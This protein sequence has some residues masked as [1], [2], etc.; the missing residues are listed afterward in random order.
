[1][2]LDD[3]LLEKSK[4]WKYF[5]LEIDENLIEEH[6][7]SPNFKEKKEAIIKIIETLHKKL[8]GNCQ[9]SLKLF[10]DLKKLESDFLYNFIYYRDHLSHSFQ[11]FLLGCYLIEVANTNSLPLEFL[12]S[13]NKDR[14]I[15]TWF[16]ISIFHDIGYFS[17]EL[18]KI[19]KKISKIYFENISG[20]HLSKLELNFSEGLINIFKDYL[21][22]I[23]NG[24]V[25]GEK[26][27]LP[28]HKEVEEL[29]EKKK[30]VL[31]ELQENFQNR[32]HG[33]ISSLFLFYTLNSDIDFIDPKKKQSFCEDIKITCTAISSHDVQK[34]GKIHLDFHKNPFSSLLI[35]C[36]SIQEWN[37]P[38]NIYEVI[39]APINWKDL[40]IKI[41]DKIYEFNFELVN[42][43]DL[44]EFKKK[45]FEELER[46][47]LN[48]IIS[49]PDFS[50]SFKT[51]KLEFKI[52]LIFDN[53][54]NIYQINEQKIKT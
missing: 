2:K 45:I 49:G 6:N 1:L 54:A 7:N 28:T 29:N 17:Q 43:D 33:V 46:I 25:F 23:S 22:L 24:L 16:L 47:F 18:R 3:N 27:F 9:N 20:A 4:L 21:D 30:I 10:R 50:I 19:G 39:N 35:L 12:S 8:I 31:N 14:F 53:N 34:Q 32:N 51:D 44:E 11:I 36:D 5:Q 52:L 26:I 42:I 38:K 15:R 40:E 13:M 41:Q 37:R 48:V